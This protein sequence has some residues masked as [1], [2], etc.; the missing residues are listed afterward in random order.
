MKFK[1]ILIFL[2]LLFCMTANARTFYVSNTDSCL[3]EN[4]IRSNKVQELVLNMRFKVDS[5]LFKRGERFFININ[6]H[7]DAQNNIYFG[8]YGDSL[9]PD[10]VLDGSIYRFDF[11]ADLWNDHEIINGVKFYKKHTGKIPEVYSVSAGNTR[12]I[13]AREPDPGEFAV[14]ETKNSFAGYFKIDSVDTDHNKSVFFDR[15]NIIDWSGAELVIKTRLWQY[16]L[17]KI[18][19]SLPYFEVTEPTVNPIIENWG[20]FIQKHFSALDSPNE[21][22]YDDEKELLYFSTDQRKATMYLCGALEEDSGFNIKNKKGIIVENFQFEN[23]RYGIFMQSTSN[24]RISNNSFRNGSFGLTN[25]KTYLENCV[26]ENNQIKNMDSYGIRVIGNNLNLSGNTIDSIGILPGAENRGLINLVGIEIHGSRNRIRNNIIKNTGYCGIRFFGTGEIEV[27]GNMLENTVLAMSDGG[28]I[29]TW[30]YFEGSKNKIIRKNIVKNAYGNA[31]GTSSGTYFKSN[32]IYLDELS[33]HFKVDSNYISNCGGGI[34]VQN[35]RC[36]TLIA[37]NI[38]DVNTFA[39]HINHAG[40]ILNGGR[41]NLENDPD[42]N[43]DN[44]SSIPEG[45]VWDKAERVLYFKNIRTGTVYIEPGNNL[46][47]NNI[48]YP[49]TDKYTFTFRTWRHIDDDTVFKLTGNRDFFRNNIPSDMIKN[50]SFQII[51]GNVKDFYQNGQNFDNLISTFDRT[52][53]DYLRKVHIYIGRGAKYKVE[54]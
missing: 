52:K 50:A 41:L 45:Y 37:N 16:E 39:L 26:I 17:R 40:S 2:I 18:K 53:Y 12:L 8:A 51:G 33:L 27:Y 13:P 32:G 25:K 20:Y 21:W 22:Y 3:T 38:K 54:K 29:Y 1:K 14:T 49:D 28:A 11:D 23:Y 31:D 48:I 46:F 15:K 44:L 34:Y 5:V 6:L 7:R 42:F 43:P 47:K 35:S 10:P 30:H 9:L 36:D 4:K 24:I 19:S